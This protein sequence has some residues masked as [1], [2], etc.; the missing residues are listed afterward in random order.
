MR[1]I[2]F[3]DS[4]GGGVTF[5][6]GEPFCQ[7]NFLLALLNV[8][9]KLYLNTAVET[10][11]AGALEDYE[12]AMPFLDMLFLDVKSAD[13]EKCLNWIGYTLDKL[14]NNIIE[15]SCIA[16][17]FNVP[18]FIRVPVIPGFNETKEDIRLV[19][20]FIRSLPRTDG[21]EL[22]PYHKLGSVK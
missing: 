20:D 3:Y 12:K 11:G 6:G 2:N 14:Q 10:C 19:I 9:A 5:S 18:L 4:T 17:R 16:Q 8:A 15:I 7:P 22:L 1:D 21:V 13:S